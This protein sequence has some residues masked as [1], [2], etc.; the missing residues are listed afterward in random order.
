M[1]KVL[2]N[3]VDGAWRQVVFL[4]KYK[5]DISLLVPIFQHPFVVVIHGDVLIVVD[6]NTRFL[7]L[8]KQF[9]VKTY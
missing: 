6:F 2:Q 3:I 8:L 1:A 9:R 7:Q 5:D 4:G